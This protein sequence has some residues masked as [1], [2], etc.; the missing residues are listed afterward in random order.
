MW[1]RIKYIA[2]KTGYV[3]L[4]VLMVIS[5]IFAAFNWPVRSKNE[6]MKFGVSFSQIFARDIGLDWKETYVAILDDLGAK[7][8]R[9]AAYWTEIEKQPG[10][11]DFSDLDYLLNE[12]NKRDVDIILAFGIKAPRWPECF[13]P[14]F[15]GGNPVEEENNPKTAEE[16]KQIKAEREEA[17][18]RYEKE[19]INRYKGFDNIRIWQV[20]NEPFLPFG[21]C[22]QGAIDSQLIDRE[23]AQVRELDETRKIMVTDSGELSIWYQAAKRADIFGTTLYRII[24]KP[25]FGYIK[26]PL[27]PSFFRIKAWFI[28]T[29][30]NQDRVMISELQ[31]EPWGSGW[32]P[33]LSIEEQ[34]KSMNPDM[35]VEVVDYARR[36]NFSDSYLWGAEWWYWLK[37]K[38]DK[39]EMWE[40]AK[41]LLRK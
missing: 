11:Y 8:L 33:N 41:G 12:A 28:H 21:H 1:E 19:L 4:G 23:I 13:I 20:E 2:K 6:N 9:L 26:Y 5:I 10:V 36:T 24:H 30:A 27:G 31:A 3:L 37:V 17:L 7:R 14:G 35:F 16:Q 29:F 25:P 15:Y 32:L 18:L 22:V 34:Y 38:H 40:L 39:P